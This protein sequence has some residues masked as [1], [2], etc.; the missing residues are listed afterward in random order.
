MGFIAIRFGASGAFVANPDCMVANLLSYMKR[1]CNE[2]DPKVFLDLADEDGMLINL[3]DYHPKK[4]ASSILSTKTMYIPIKL[5]RYADGS[6]K[7]YVPLVPDMNQENPDFMRRLAV[8]Y[9]RRTGKTIRGYGRL[10]SLPEDAKLGKNVNTPPT[11]RNTSQG[12][13]GTKGTNRA[14]KSR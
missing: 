12:N 3:N 7:P 10:Q 4:R 13:K 1:M 11:K 8:Q 2:H 9:E 6:L 5:E 14:G